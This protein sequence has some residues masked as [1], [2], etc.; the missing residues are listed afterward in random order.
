MLIVADRTQAMLQSG[1]LTPSMPRAGRRRTRLTIDTLN[2]M[3]QQ[4]PEELDAVFAALADPTRRAIV[5]RLT[6][7]EA[8]VSELSE[9]FA[10]T[11]TAVAKHLRVLS[12]AGLVE[13]RKEGRVR[14]CR[15]APGPLLDLHVW[16]GQ[17]ARFWEG[18][19]DSLAAHVGG[20]A[21]D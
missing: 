21:Q 14:H 13:H 9:P 5:Q 17:Y 12:D 6:V 16:L 11:L 4:S 15:L 20:P 10:M 7:G 3:V 8:S 1:E 2:L 19:L 18:Q